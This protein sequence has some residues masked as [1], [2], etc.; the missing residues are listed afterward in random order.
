MFKAIWG[1]FNCLTPCVLT[2]FAQWEDNK[3]GGTRTLLK[4]HTGAPSLSCHGSSL[5]LMEQ[6]APCACLPLTKCSPPKYM[7]RSVPP[8]LPGQCKPPGQDLPCVPDQCQGLEVLPLS[9]VP[10]WNTSCQFSDESMEVRMERQSQAEGVTPALKPPAC[11]GSHSVCTT[12][13]TAGLPLP[14]R[15]F[16]SFAQGS[17]PWCVW[18]GV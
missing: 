15:A 14:H 10:S 5:L 16:F 9:Q 8:S 17:G 11:V 1:V 13:F 12:P 3:L 2:G 6:R 18:G 7:Q 4:T